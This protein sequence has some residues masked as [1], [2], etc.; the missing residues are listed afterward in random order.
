M[1]NKSAFK[2][3]YALS[4]AS[5]LGFIIAA[6]IVGFLIL[7][8]WLDEIFDSSPIILIVGLVLAITVTIY[9]I[10]HL[11]EPLTGGDNKD[12]SH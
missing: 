1:Q 11:L 9:E 2:T 7:G 5:Q 10:Y 3:F 4:F 12:D 8:F 6:P